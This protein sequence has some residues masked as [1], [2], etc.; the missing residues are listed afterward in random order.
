[1]SNYFSSHIKSPK[2]ICDKD[3]II[4]YESDTPFSPLQVTIERNFDFESEIIY[5]CNLDSKK[6]PKLCNPQSPVYSTTN[7]SSDLG[8]SKEFTTPER[9]P[10]SFLYKNSPNSLR[11][12]GT[13]VSNESQDYEKEIIRKK[14]KK[15]NKEKL[16]RK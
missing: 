9:N 11:L 16:K 4:D 1:M 5:S 14:I 6:L 15:Y 7:S 8:R 13:P 10:L 3:N 12:P 2:N